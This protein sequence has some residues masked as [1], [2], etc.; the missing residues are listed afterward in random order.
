VQR[1]PELCATHSK[2]SPYWR[3]LV[4]A[5]DLAKSAEANP[6]AK[7]SLPSARVGLFYGLNCSK[8]F[9]NIPS[10]SV[11]TKSIRLHTEPAGGSGSVRPILF[12]RRAS[13]SCSLSGLPR[14][15]CCVVPLS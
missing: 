14:L 4:G 7:N 12:S 10:R 8:A 1:G 13:A 11:P 15:I 9:R 3:K 2:E 5:F 6:L